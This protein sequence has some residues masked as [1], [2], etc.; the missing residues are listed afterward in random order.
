MK[1]REREIRDMLHVELT[2][3]NKTGPPKLYENQAKRF[4][5]RPRKRKRKSQYVKHV[6]VYSFEEQCHQTL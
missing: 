1:T 3:G 2:R 4:H 6:R 5:A